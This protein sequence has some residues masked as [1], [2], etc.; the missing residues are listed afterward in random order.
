MPEPAVRLAFALPRESRVRL[1]VIDL[2]GREVAVLANGTL[3]AGRHEASWNTSAGH[4]V[5]AP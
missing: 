2:Q 1:R 4:L 5:L 3:P